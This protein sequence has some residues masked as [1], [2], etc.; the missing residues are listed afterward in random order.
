[1]KK[2]SN[3]NKTDRFN[4]QTT[5]RIQIG[6]IRTAARGQ[7]LRRTTTK[8]DHITKAVNKQY[9]HTEKTDHPE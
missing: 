5:Q 4:K 8:P 1:M 3:K 9:K 2:A 7:N 6:R